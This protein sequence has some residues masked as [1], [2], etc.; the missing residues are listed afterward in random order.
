MSY[1]ARIGLLAATFTFAFSACSKTQ[2]DTP[3]PKP[4]SSSPPATAE[5]PSTALTQ[6]EI[7]QL[8]DASTISLVHLDLS[9][10]NP[11]YAPPVAEGT[12]YSLRLMRVVQKLPD[13]YFLQAF[14]S[15]GALSTEFVFL[16]TKED[17]EENHLFTD[18][19]NWAICYGKYEYSGVNGFRRKVW[20]FVA[21]SSDA[22]QYIAERLKR[23][24]TK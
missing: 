15:T 20:A 14:S 22:N 19:D 7:R 1:L 5:K 17:L 10:A 23:S 4:V 24:D 8:I 9:L 11:P 18:R 16:K 3:P 2:T 21:F 6:T 13:G 12:I